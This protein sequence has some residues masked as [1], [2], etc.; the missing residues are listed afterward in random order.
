MTT[1]LYTNHWSKVPQTATSA[2][3]GH[4]E[5]G[6]GAAQRQLSDSRPIP[7]DEE[8]RSKST[9]PESEDQ[10]ADELQVEM[11]R[12]NRV[13]CLPKRRSHADMSCLRRTLES[14]RWTPFSWPAAPVTSVGI[15]SPI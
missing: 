13:Q 11:S 5:A 12:I 7:V 14:R 9:G 15:W 6:V 2:A 3:G 1:A 4:T 10:G 8:P